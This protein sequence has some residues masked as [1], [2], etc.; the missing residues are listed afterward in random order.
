MSV[1]VCVCV[2][3]YMCMCLFVYMCLYTGV[4]VCVCMYMYACM[5][6]YGCTYLNAFFNNWGFTTKQNQDLCS[7]I[8]EK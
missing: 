5:P 7:D 2:Y 1:C 3:K 4:C 8:S 6:E